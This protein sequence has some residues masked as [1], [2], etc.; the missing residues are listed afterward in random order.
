M[1]YTR[2]NGRNSEADFMIDGKSWKCILSTFL[3]DVTTDQIPS[4]TF[5]SEPNEE[6]EPGNTTILCTIGGN[7]VYGTGDVGEPTGAALTLI[8]P[9]QHVPVIAQFDEN[10]TIGF[11]AN[12]RR[13]TLNRIA[14][15]NSVITGEAFSTGIIA[16]V[17]TGPTP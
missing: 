4:A 6:F 10:C 7:L 12:F 1:A 8:P 5:C 14:N 3:I 15:N 11:D 9:P 13:A 2:I 17:W 16:V